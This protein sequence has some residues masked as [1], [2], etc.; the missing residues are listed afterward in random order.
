MAALSRLKNQKF[1]EAYE[2]A[3]KAAKSPDPESE[4]APKAATLCVRILL[5]EAGEVKDDDKAK[6]EE[7]RSALFKRMQSVAEF[8]LKKW[9]DRAEADEV[10]I[11]LGRGAALR[12][13]YDEAIKALEGVSERSLSFPQA[14]QLA[15]TL[16]YHLYAVAKSKPAEQRDQALIDSERDQAEKQLLAGLD[17]LKKKQAAGEGPSE[18]LLDLQQLLGDV[19]YEKGDFKGAAALL[20]PI[21]DSYKAK[22]P[23]QIDKSVQRTFILAVRSYNGAGEFDK[24]GAAAESL[25][26]LSGEDSPQINSIAVNF[27][28]LLGEE[29]KAAEAALTDAKTDGDRAKIDDAE[30][31]VFGLKGN[32][33]KLLEKLGAKQNHTLD[34]RIYMG[35]IAAKIGATNLAEQFYTTALAQVDKE[36]DSVGPKVLKFIP[37]IRAQLVGLL[38]QKGEFKT[39][40]EQIDKLIEEQPK[41]L[42]PKVVKARLLQAWAEKEPARLQDAAR[43]W[44]GIARMLA[45][46]A[47][48]RKPLPELFEAN[49]YAASCLYMEFESTKDATKADTA[50]KLLHT[51][52]IKSPS[53]SGPDM[54]AKYNA[55]IGKIN[56]AI[57]GATV[58]TAKNPAAAK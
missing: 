1:D 21:I 19:K 44:A 22:K 38:Q 40:V 33:T 49:Y 53:L 26:D 27:V 52:M 11:A 48:G 39:G 7:Q 36:K 9:G 17:N 35:G 2:L 15:G 55:L 4:V 6:E 54:V 30:A 47:R 32:I 29:Y 3:S 43:E 56:K 28:G 12:G 46:A 57:G 14:C 34:G 42:E 51:M 31:R 25:I 8:T 58:Q 41:A 20:Q 50:R 45:G 13:Q 18:E 16:H 24:G 5:A 23:E 10:R 37:Q